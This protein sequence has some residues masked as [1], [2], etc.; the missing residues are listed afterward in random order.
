MI[1]IQQYNM[2]NVNTLHM[3]NTLLQHVLPSQLQVLNCA[4]KMT[5]LVT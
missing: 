4:A 2:N 5:E 3:T 1:D